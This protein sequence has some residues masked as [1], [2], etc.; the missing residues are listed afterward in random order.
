MQIPRYCTAAALAAFAAISLQEASATRAQQQAPTAPAAG[1]A[2]FVVFVNG[3]EA[4]REQVTVSRTPSGWTI[5]SSGRLG[6]PLNFTNNRFEVTYAPDWQPIEL[7]FD[8][9]FQDKSL[10]LSTSFGTTTA[11]SE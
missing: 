3:R 4:G 5:A 1:E 7:R 2:T 11:V 8:A 6:P 10:T 9:R